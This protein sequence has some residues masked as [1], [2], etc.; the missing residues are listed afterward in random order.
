MLSLDTWS[1]STNGNFSFLLTNMLRILT[2]SL[3]L[4]LIVWHR[5][6]LLHASHLWH[7]SIRGII[8]LPTLALSK[9]NSSSVELPYFGTIMGCLQHH[10]AV[11]KLLNK[12]V[13]AL[14]G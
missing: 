7:G 13:F 8:K 12:A 2:A 3:H 1:A 10:R 9:S 11:S 6:E 4:R 5:E 14:D